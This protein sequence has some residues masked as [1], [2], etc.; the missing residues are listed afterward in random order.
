M[1]KPNSNR[2]AKRVNPNSHLPKN[3]QV[4]IQTDTKD[5][6]RDVRQLEKQVE[7]LGS[8]S[9]R[10]QTVQGGFLSKKQ[11]AYFKD[12][13]RQMD[14]LEKE[15]V[16]KLDDFN[17]EVAKRQ[18][19]YNDAQAR[20]A[21]PTVT[22]FY[23]RKLDESQAMQKTQQTS[24]NRVLTQTN[25]AQ[26][27]MDK[28]ND[29]HEMGRGGRDLMHGITRAAGQAGMVYS[30][31]RLFG[32]L[33]NGQDLVRAQE[34][35]GARIGMKMGGYNGD[36]RQT[37][38]DAQDVGIKNGYNSFD[39]MNTQRTLLAGGTTGS[40]ENLAKDTESVQTLSRAYAVDPYT[41]ADSSSALK[42]M[43]SVEEGDQ[44]RFANLLAGA[45]EKTQSRGRE[46]EMIRATTNLV[47][48]VGNNLGTMSKEQ[49]GNVVAYQ[50]QLGSAIPSLNGQRGADLM[51]GVDS[52]IKGGNESMD[53]L[54]G[55]GTK[56][57]GPEGMWN[58]RMQKE[59]GIADPANLTSIMKNI[60][61]HVN[62]EYVRKNIIAD[63]LGQGGVSANKVEELSKAGIL[64]QWS[65]GQGIDQE[66]VA[67]LIQEGSDATDKR[68]A[69]YQSSN[70]FDVK[71]NQAKGQKLQSTLSNPLEKTVTGGKA[72]FFSQPTWLQ[73]V[74]TVGGGIFGG[75]AMSK[76]GSKVI[77]GIARLFGRNIGGGGGL[78]SRLGNLFRGGGG[79][80]DGAGGS[81]IWSKITGLFRG[82]AG[83]GAG[84]SGGTGFLGKIGNFLKGFG[85]K[86]GSS[87]L[88]GRLGGLAG[89]VAGGFGGGLI[90]NA[91]WPEKAG[92]SNNSEIDAIQKWNQEHGVAP[93]TK[94]S[95]WRDPAAEAKES[96][97][98][99]VTHEVKV[100]VD[101]K[102]DGMTPENQGQVNNSF[103][104]YFNN[105]FNAQVNTSGVDLSRDT[106]RR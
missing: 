85:G 44:R 71:S 92:M 59:K 73:G 87:Q 32:Y 22:N 12:I 84:E 2:P 39:T 27:H 96:S 102:I 38:V 99:K 31:G 91:L 80:A 25:N 69:E 93:S 17:K 56:F 48:Q 77:P 79:G 82:G 88:L 1:A 74:E 24:T 94:T 81:G 41:V 70:D 104:E 43:G 3:V 35:R 29:M 7:R 40:K 42:R 19:Q 100:T 50:A 105:V 75:L 13:V 6:M 47:T 34:D 101:G 28:I 16:S 90:S 103:Q 60:N 63:M 51:S 33:N 66:A 89:G 64:D 67:K 55:K 11:V 52:A 72:G 68:S 10:G 5:A 8:M 9:H 97:D 36:F 54:L 83:S 30:M 58:L 46:A 65:N 106:V 20:G 37:V 62:G 14:Q 21:H 53:V 45:I 15:Y 57:V 98:V 86:I 49:M 78:M 95:D 61:S 76:I 4:R 26:Q 18:N 23:K